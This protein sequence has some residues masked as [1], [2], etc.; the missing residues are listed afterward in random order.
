MKTLTYTPELFADIMAEVLDYH[1][2]GETVCG[3]EDP[4][5]ISLTNGFAVK[6]PELAG[7]GTVRV[8]D[9]YVNAWKSDT[10]L[11]FSNREITDEEYAQYD[12][13][14]GE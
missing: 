11:E 3:A 8:I 13:L 4:A 1:Q 12:E 2:T 6:H 9:R 14:A 5:V 7:F 10:L